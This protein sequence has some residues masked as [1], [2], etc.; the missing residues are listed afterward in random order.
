MSFHNIDKDL[1]LGIL[2]TNNMYNILAKYK[3]SCDVSVNDILREG[4]KRIII[5]D[6]L[7]T[8][9]MNRQRLFLATE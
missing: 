1:K 4:V 9:E 3:I 7:L 6:Y 2:H 8:A 5:K